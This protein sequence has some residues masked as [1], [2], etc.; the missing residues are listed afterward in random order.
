MLGRSGQSFYDVGNRR[1]EVWGQ[2]RERVRGRMGE[3]SSTRWEVCNVCLFCLRI[4]I[5][6]CESFKI[7]EGCLYFIVKIFLFICRF[8]VKFVFFGFICQEGKFGVFLVVVMSFLYFVFFVYFFLFFVSVIRIRILF[9][10]CRFFS[11]LELFQ[12]MEGV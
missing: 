11:C 5:F 7:F 2:E 10:Y 4:G 12:Y 1:V 8:V 9:G 6:F 3:Q